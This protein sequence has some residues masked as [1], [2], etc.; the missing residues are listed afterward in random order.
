MKREVLFL[1]I[2]FIIA[3]ILNIYA[4]ITYQTEW[5][6]L[7]TYLPIV[8][9]LTCVIYFLLLII[10]GLLWSVRKVIKSVWKPR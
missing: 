9:L 7:V 4:I 1:L 8:L 2:G 5:K 10:R 3:N 6:E